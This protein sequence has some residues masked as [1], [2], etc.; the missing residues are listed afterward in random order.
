LDIAVVD[1]AIGLLISAPTGCPQHK[2]DR[3]PQVVHVV[4]S[5][6]SAAI[7]S[8]SQPIAGL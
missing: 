6:S 1:R 2:L 3:L 4:V 8:L 7:N 5:F